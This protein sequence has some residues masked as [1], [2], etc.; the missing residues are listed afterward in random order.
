[1]SASST[2]QPKSSSSSH[3]SNPVPLNEGNE[4]AKNVNNVA[5]DKLGEKETKK[6]T[7]SSLKDRV[8]T[9]IEGA[10]DKVCEVASKVWGFISKPF[11]AAYNFVF[12]KDKAENTEKT[13]KPNTTEANPEIETPVETGTENKTEEET[14]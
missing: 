4:Q 12:K 11:I 13:D 10:W 9:F 1:M 5:T 3:S 6:S 14:K 7:I 2:I 8:V